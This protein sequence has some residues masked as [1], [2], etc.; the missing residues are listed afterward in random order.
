MLPSRVSKRL[1][2]LTILTSVCL[3]S[4]SYAA[5]FTARNATQL[6]RAL[7]N[8]RNNGD[9]RD[10]INLRGRFTASNFSID[11]PVTINGGNRS[12]TVITNNGSAVFFVR[13]DGVVIR[14]VGIRN[15]ASGFT[16]GIWVKAAQSTI[17]RR[18]DIRGVTTGVGSFGMVPKGSQVFDNIFRNTDIGVGFHRDSGRHASLNT[19]AGD[20]IDPNPFFGGRM[21]IVD[22]NIDGCRIGISIDHGNDGREF[23]GGQVRFRAEFYDGSRRSRELTNYRT[24]EAE[25]SRNV[26]N[27]ARL[28]G[29]ALAKTGQVFIGS[30]NIAMADTDDFGGFGAGVHLEH[31]SAGN[32]IRDNTISTAAD[33]QRCI[34]LAAFTDHG[35]A[36]RFNERV[37]S[38]V[39]RDNTT[40]GTAG[41]SVGGDAYSDVEIFANDFRGLRRFFTTASAPGGTSSFSVNRNNRGAPGG[42]VPSP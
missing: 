39:I 35:S 9:G 38:L 11:S 4:S 34:N 29:I 8:A 5:T 19:A 13:S 36:N 41:A 40:S 7:N 18:C 42:R 6:T 30:N 26:I 10:T 28:F 17:V 23:S 20:A 24:G 37:R 12:N 1:I 27:N 31:R 16:V 14:N 25:I 15:S 32:T 21:R 33:N 22:N 2:L 3:P